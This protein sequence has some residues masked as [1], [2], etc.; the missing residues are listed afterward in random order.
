MRTYVVVVAGGSGKRMQAP[1]PKQ[2]LELGGEPVLFHTL[3]SL[4]SIGADFSLVLVLPEAHIDYWNELVQT[5]KFPVPHQV[6]A[7]GNTRFHSVKNGLALCGQ[8]DIIAVHDGV[9]PFIKAE[10]L[11]DCLRVA[12]E[13]GAC[14]PVLSPLE[15][16]RKRSFNGSEAVNREDFLLVQTPQVFRSEVLMDAY[17]Q[18]YQDRFTDDASVVESAG[19]QVSTCNGNRENIKITTPFDLMM[20]EMILKTFSPL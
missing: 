16:I 18:P 7:G 9:R 13:T 15:S 5:K 20:G 3:R 11:R 8:A 6:T 10:M 2:F 4:H 19:H 14:I 12:G 1:V 17:L